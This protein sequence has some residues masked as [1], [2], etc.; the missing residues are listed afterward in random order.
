MTVSNI[1][2]GSEVA[3]SCA[4]RNHEISISALPDIDTARLETDVLP[5]LKTDLYG[6]S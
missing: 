2:A 3:Y 1:A 4:G 6:E 5:D